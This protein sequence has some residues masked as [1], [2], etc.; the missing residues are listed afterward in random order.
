MAVL[1]QQPQEMRENVRKVSVDLW[2]GFQ[3]VIREVFLNALIVIDRFHV[4]K[5]VNK[6]VNQIRLDREIK[7]LKNR[8]LI[9][10]NHPNLSEEERSDLEEIL[11]KS[12]CLRIVYE[13]KEEL[14]LRKK[15]LACLFK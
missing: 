5:L 14:P 7:G 10:R 13:L 6:A 1:E 3:K 9:L 4:M 15:L 2:E 8:V 12:A 11:Q